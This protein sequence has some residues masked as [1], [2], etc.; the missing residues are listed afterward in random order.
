ML[1]ALGFS[2]YSRENF[3]ILSGEMSDCYTC[4]NHILGRRG[5]GPVTEW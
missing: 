2:S 5:Y 4:L 3:L 1:E